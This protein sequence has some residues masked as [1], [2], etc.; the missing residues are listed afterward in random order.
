MSTT[1]TI[2]V[3]KGRYYPPGAPRDEKERSIY[4]K[5]TP[6]SAPQVEI[7]RMVVPCFDEQQ[8]PPLLQT[9]EEK[10]TSVNNAAQL[11]ERMIKGGPLLVPTASL[12]PPQYGAVA[13]P[14]SLQPGLMQPSP[15]P[16]PQ[17]PPVNPA[18]H[19]QPVMPYAATPPNSAAAVPPLMLFVNINAAPTEFG[20]TS[21]IC[22]PGESNGDAVSFINREAV[23]NHCFMSQL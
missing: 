7:P 12:P 19:Q 20:L 13:P 2:I 21:K 22:G 15:S 5:I 3:T 8:I 17:H 1:G 9:E 14:P 11:V 18:T 10:Y 6:G 23:S 4:L 16:Q